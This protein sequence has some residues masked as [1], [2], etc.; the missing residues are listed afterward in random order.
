VNY[1]F[2][3]FYFL[4]DIELLNGLKK[5]GPSAIDVEFRSL[6]EEMGGSVELMEKFLKF[7]LYL[8]TTRKNFE[9]ANSYLALF[10]KLHSNTISLE[11]DLVNVLEQIKEIHALSWKNLQLYF[12]K[13]LCL[14]SYLKSVT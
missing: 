12:N 7:I 8:L 10:L 2:E 1:L 13:N 5:I 9:L 14:V 3:I 6:S 11:N 4:I